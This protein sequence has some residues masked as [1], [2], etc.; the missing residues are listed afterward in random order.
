MHCSRKT[1]QHSYQYTLSL[2]VLGWRK[3]LGYS[4]LGCNVM[5]FNKQYFPRYKFRLQLVT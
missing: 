4:C 1:T 2:L 3:M 5:I